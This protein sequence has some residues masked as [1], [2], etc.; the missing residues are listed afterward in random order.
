M[1]DH[2]NVSYDSRGHIGDPGGGT[3]PENQVVGRA[4]LILWPPSR[5][6]T[7][8]IPST[9]T[10]LNDS[11]AALAALASSAAPA[12]VAGAAAMPLLLVE[13]RLRR[14]VSASRAGARLRR[15]RGHW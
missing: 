8:N 2:R 7:L 9:F 15:R 13:R 11:S 10:K 14:R 4:F 3:I 6:R 1:G 12:A 5:F